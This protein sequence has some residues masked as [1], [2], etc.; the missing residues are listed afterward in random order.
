M[1]LPKILAVMPLALMLT[2]GAALAEDKAPA[3][4]ITLSGTGELKLAPDA[5]VVSIGV[6]S[7]AKTAKDAL[8]ANTKAVAGIVEQVKAAGIEAK[9]LRTAQFSINPTYASRKRADGREV[10]EVVGYNVANVVSVRVAPIDKLGPLLDQV[11]QQ[12]ANQINGLDFVVDGADRK[13]DEARAAAIADARRKAE[14]YVAG[15]GARLGRVLSISEAGAHPMPVF[16]A[17]RAMAAEMAAAPVPVE[18][19]EETLSAQVSVTWEI[20]NAGN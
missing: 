4:T 11:V 5:A 20:V 12:G 1:S 8:A 6:S 9:N 2:G 10:Q 7:D 14:I 13:L 19:G 18:A 17:T 3:A 16:K 15:A